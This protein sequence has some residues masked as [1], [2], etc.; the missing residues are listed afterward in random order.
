M[1]YNSGLI[2]WKNLAGNFAEI[3][4]AFARWSPEMKRNYFWGKKQ[5]SVGTTMRP[6]REWMV[7]VEEEE[8]QEEEEEEEEVVVVV[9]VCCGSG[10]Y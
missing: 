3:S 9:V 10:Q 4:K 5:V 8:E 1:I 2:D 7:A 6:G